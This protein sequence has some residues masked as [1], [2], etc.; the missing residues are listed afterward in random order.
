MTVSNLNP[1]TL[2]VVHCYA[3]DRQQVLDLLPVYEHHECPIVIIS[4]DDSPVRDIG[5]HICETAGKRAYIGQDSWDRQYLQLKRLLK[6]PQKWFLLNDSDSFCVTPKLPEFLYRD[7]N[8]VWSNEVDDFRKDMPEFGP[9]FHLPLAQIAMQPPYFLSRKALQAIVDNTENMQA[10]PVCPFIDWWWVPA[11]DKGH[12]KHA[13]Y[14][15]CASCETVTPNGV[16]VMSQCVGERGASFLHSIKSRSVVDRMC[17]LY[18][19]S[20]PNG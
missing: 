3:G 12:V 20:Y 15:Q 18:K 4:P 2:V 6:Y 13:R 8:V 11:C 1:D 17:A 16:A 19:S 7:D 14:P 9:Q 10:C 5:P